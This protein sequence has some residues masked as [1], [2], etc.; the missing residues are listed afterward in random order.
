MTKLYGPLSYLGDAVLLSYS[1]CFFSRSRVAALFF[2]AATFVYPA[3][4]LCG[5]CS[6]LAA[7]GIALLLGFDRALIRNGLY[8]ISP[9]AVGL[10]AAFRFEITPSF[11]PFWLLAVVL[12]VL[13]V[14][15]FAAAFEPTF[16]L[17]Q[18]SLSFVCVTVLM[19]LAAVYFV[20]LP[21]RVHNFMPR[22]LSMYLPHMRSVD[23]YL[24]AL[25]A[26]FF[27][28]DSLSGALVFAGLLFASRI[29]AVLSVIGFA[30]G[31]F[32]YSHIGGNPY[33]VGLAFTG[34]NFVFCAIS[35]GGI[36]C[37][38][39]YSSYLLALVSTA[40]CALVS[41]G[42]Y[43]V[44]N[45][46]GIYIFSIPYLVIMFIFLPA[47]RA[48][49]ENRLPERVAYPADSPEDN[50]HIAQVWRLREGV[51]AERS[52]RLPFMGPWRV[53]Q[54]FNGRHTHRD[55][56]RSALDFSLA[57]EKGDTGAGMTA[58]G[59]YGMPVIAPR[60]GTVAA[61]TEHLPDNAAG[62]M[63]AIN[64]WGNFASI[65]HDDGQYSLVAHLKQGSLRVRPGDSVKAGEVIAACGNSGRS[66]V[67]HLHFQVQKTPLPG[68]ETTGFTFVRYLLRGDDCVLRERA[69]PS[70]DEVVE[71]P[72]YSPAMRSAVSFSSDASYRFIVDSRSGRR[73]ET[74]SGGVD[75]YGW[76]FLESLHDGSRLY[77]YYL[78]EM[79]FAGY[80]SARPGSLV[81]ALFAAVSSVPLIEQR[82]V[83]WTDRL[84][85]HHFYRSAARP[86]VE[87][88]LPFMPG[89]S[90]LAR[91]TFFDSAETGAV[92]GIATEMSG[93]T[94]SSMGALRIEAVF[95]GEGISTLSL[96]EDGVVSL[97]AKRVAAALSF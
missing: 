97:S 77:F 42:A 22:T 37:V 63:D 71:N 85:L 82:S 31:S 51:V 50:L 48:R 30:A 23:G 21:T 55:I 89:T 1:G 72:V 19:Y 91:R 95:S 56:W 12:T 57:P 2:M 40:V 18:L 52:F 53:T 90:V 62:E 61:I 94:L 84:P 36:F 35:L 74:L 47:L 49:A 69:V 87:M 13:L 73:E 83:R 93:P 64:N 70:E 46:L 58:A 79:F 29:S 7:I 16:A 78:D 15:A 17:P 88:L 20:F 5:L 44:L 65:R 38:P 86:A 41:A 81:W 27:R 60:S 66:P 9:L 68:G 8:S 34:L 4:G 67:P 92:V 76:T 28:G 43:A 33:D 6:V 75:L 11:I 32:A 10:A 14:A 24:R 59:P 45:P 3:E 25:A 80:C 26:T 39:S 54:G 96:A